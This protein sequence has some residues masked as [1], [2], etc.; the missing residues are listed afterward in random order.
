MSVIEMTVDRMPWCQYLALND[1]F[2]Q[3]LKEKQKKKQKQKT[4]KKERRDRDAKIEKDRDRGVE[5]EK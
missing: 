1:C 2:W 5:T 3:V 4:R